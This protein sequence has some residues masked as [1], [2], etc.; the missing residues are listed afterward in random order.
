MA[1]FGALIGSI[2]L[3]SVFLAFAIP[4]AILW[5]IVV[6]IRNIAGGPPRPNRQQQG[7]TPRDPAVDELR[8]RY[9]RGEISQAEFEQRMWDLGYEKVR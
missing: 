9:A 3:F 5:L 7:W 6:V 4:I 1:A 2:V 8:A